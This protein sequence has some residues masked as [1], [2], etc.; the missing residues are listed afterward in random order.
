MLA[1]SA[2][3]RY[4]FANAATGLDAVLADDSIDAVS[5][6]LPSPTQT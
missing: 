4:G 3:A 5:L 1:R 6:A 2:A